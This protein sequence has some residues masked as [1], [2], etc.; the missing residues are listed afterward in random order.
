LFTSL[1]ARA[2]R[3][4]QDQVRHLVVDP[5]GDLLVL[6][7]H[8]AGVARADIARIGV[9]LAEADSR[10]DLE[11]LADAV[12]WAVAHDRA[13]ARAALAPLALDRDFR[14]AVRLLARTR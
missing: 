3:L 8:A 12:D 2:G 6:L 13:A 5:H 9:A 11:R 4:E 1:L 14:A 7:L 10:R